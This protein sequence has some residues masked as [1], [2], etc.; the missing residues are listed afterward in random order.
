MRD[1]VAVMAVVAAKELRQRLRDRSALFTAFVAPLVLAVIISAGLGGS[2]GSFHGHAAVADEDGGP[3]AGAFIAALRTPQLRTIISFEQVHD[4]AAARRKVVDGHA[5]AAFVIPAGLSAA[6]Q[7]GGRATIDVLGPRANPIARDVASAIAAGFANRVGAVA[8][9][10]RTALATGAATPADLTSLIARASAAP[11]AV[12]TNDVAQRDGFRPG[13]YFAPA[14]AIF[15][16][17]FTAS[18]AIRSLLAERATGT[19]ARLLVAPIPRWSVV[20][21]KALATFVTGLVALATL[22]VASRV[23]M[24]AHWGDPFAVG[25]L[26]V[27]TVAAML[28]LASLVATLAKTEEQANAYTSIVGLLL[29]LLGGNFLPGGPAVLRRISLFTPNGWALRGFTDLGGHQHLGAITTNL[30]VLMAV[31]IAGCTLAAV[32]ARRLVVT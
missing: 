15:F 12:T 8:V 25:V 17:F 27:V 22:I 4:A 7:S 21:G 32:R 11:P 2:V 30:I 9:A 23:L 13:A 1:T 16:L 19:L 26:C 3:V 18:A 6:V 28:G 5:D 10:V 20:L 31:A 29:A 24:G 14:M